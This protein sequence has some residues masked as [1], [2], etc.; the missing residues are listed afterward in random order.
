MNSVSSPQGTGPLGLG[1][2][3]SAPGAQEMTPSPF[4]TKSIALCP[5]GSNANS[6][7]LL[8]ILRQVMRETTQKVVPGMPGTALLAE[9]A[10]W[11]QNALMYLMKPTGTMAQKR[12]SVRNLVKKAPRNATRDYLKALEKALVAG[13]GKGFEMASNIHQ[14]DGL[15]WELMAAAPPVEGDL[16]PEREAAGDQVACSGLLV[17]MDLPKASE[18]HQQLMKWLLQ[19]PV[20]GSLMINADQ[21]SM[22]KAGVN[23]LKWSLQ[24]TVGEFM[25]PYHRR[26]NDIT[27]CLRSPGWDKGASREG[28]LGLVAGQM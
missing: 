13:I 25:D 1:P 6:C 16:G 22:N 8:C 20:P 11:K 21:A 14:L 5:M 27:A 18:Q 9:K 24:V 3:A 15:Q 23:F 28:R 12:T 2:W 17:Q 4:S 19:A 7:A 26:W 10:G